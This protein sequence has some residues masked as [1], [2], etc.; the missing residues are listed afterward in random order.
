MKRQHFAHS[1]N[2]KF[3][4]LIFSLALFSCALPS[5][6]LP[7]VTAIPTA[8]DPSVPLQRLQVFFTNPKAPHSKDY[9]GGLDVSIANDIDQARLSVDIAAYSLNLWSIQDALIHA[10]QR[11]VAVRVVMESD[12]MGNREVQQIQDAGI[13]VVG[14]QHEGLMHDKFIVIDQTVV[15]TGSMNFTAGGTYRDNNNLLR[16]DSSKAAE[17]Y[18]G[19]FNEM[20]T[21]NLFG[22]DATVKPTYPKLSMDGTPIEILFSPNG[23]A[24][25]RIL[26]LIQNAQSSIN[27]MAYSFTSNDIGDAIIA[28]SQAGVSV[29]GVMDDG[30]VKSNEGTEYDPFQQAG[31]DVRL[32]GNETG[33]MHHKVII[34]DRQIVITGSYNFT[35]S[36]E[37]SN[38]ENIV[39]IFSTVVAEKYMDEFQ[40][41]FGQAQQP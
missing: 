38:D 28:R 26:E 3:I 1:H 37:E 2:W 10:H 40:R 32:D 31:L 4:L 36:A 6:S 8:D 15:W 27:F 18:T 16:I 5:V 13:Q 23:G 33:L 41:V 14:D 17:D 24:A 19:K 34:I 12:N 25:A 20:F 39:V 35:A 7:T 29:E 30:Q 9:Q 22:P 21:D 11:G